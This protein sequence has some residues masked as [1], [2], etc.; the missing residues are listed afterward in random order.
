VAAGQDRVDAA[1]AQGQPV[2]KKDFNLPEAE[3]VKSNET[4]TVSLL[5][6]DVVLAG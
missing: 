1:A 6:L 5:E 2:L 3:S 4:F